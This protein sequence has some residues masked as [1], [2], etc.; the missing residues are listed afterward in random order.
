MARVAHR[1]GSEPSVGWGERSE[2]QRVNPECVELPRAVGLRLRLISTYGEREAVV[3][4][5]QSNRAAYNTHLALPDPP[6]SLVLK[7][8]GRNAL[9]AFR[10]AK[11]R[12]ALADTPITALHAAFWHFVKLHDAL[13]DA[14]LAVLERILVYGPAA[15]ED[16]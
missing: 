14:Q 1:P 11:L 12:Q 15:R 7:L 3:F 6:M 2:P 13:S 10:L 5:R 9:S 4:R 16:K 8:R